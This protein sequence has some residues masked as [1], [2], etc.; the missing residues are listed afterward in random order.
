MCCTLTSV[1][2]HLIIWKISFLGRDSKPRYSQKVSIDYTEI[3][4][5]LSVPECLSFELLVF[6]YMLL[7]LIYDLLSKAFAQLT[8]KDEQP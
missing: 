3:K 5:S 7:S 8:R 2:R 1:S 6:V 4:P